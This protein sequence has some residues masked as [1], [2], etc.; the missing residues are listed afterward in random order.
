LK[1]SLNCGATVLDPVT[2]WEHVVY[3]VALI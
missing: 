1:N 3:V 2:L